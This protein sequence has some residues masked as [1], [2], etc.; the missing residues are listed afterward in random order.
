MSLLTLS[1]IFLIPLLYLNIR[2]YYVSKSRISNLIISNLKKFD[3]KYIVMTNGKPSGV[4]VSFRYKY[5]GYIQYDN[6]RNTYVTIICQK[7]IYSILTS[8]FEQ[9]K[10]LDNIDNID[11]YDKNDE[12][13][14][15]ENNN[16]NESN[17][18]L[19]YIQRTGSLSYT[20][21]ITNTIEN[22]V[23]ATKYQRNICNTIING[24]KSKKNHTYIAFLHGPAGSG[25]STI[26]FLVAKQFDN[27]AYVCNDFDPTRRADSLSEIIQSIELS[28]KRPLV[29]IIDEVDV[30]LNKISTTSS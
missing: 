21:Y 15:N 24:Y 1:M 6:E 3:V 4:F 13:D 11:Q 12:N 23:I 10:T 18:S 19:S 8:M 5:I 26:G 14:S 29:L 2:L 22:H 27:S 16:N 20:N 9:G 7:K 30:I 25:K 17:N 28:E